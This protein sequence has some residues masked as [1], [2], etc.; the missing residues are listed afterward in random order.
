[1]DNYKYKLKLMLMLILIWIG[2]VTLGTNPFKSDLFSMILVL[3][4]YV[5]WN[6]VSLV[7]TRYNQLT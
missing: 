7:I 5:E 1:M 3:V 2:I 4:P 6:I